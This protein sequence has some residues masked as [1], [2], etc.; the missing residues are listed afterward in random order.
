M[1]M[2]LFLFSY[3]VLFILLFHPIFGLE[4][5]F[6]EYHWNLYSGSERI[7]CIKKFIPKIETKETEYYSSLWVKL[8]IFNLSQSYV[9]VLVLYCV[10]FFIHVDF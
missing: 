9:E 7:Q 1:E 5:E 8:K 4:L 10:P 3:Q 2:W 6:H